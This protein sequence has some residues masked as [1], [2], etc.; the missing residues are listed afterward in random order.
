MG[1]LFI[2]VINQ[3]SYLEIKP[4]KKMK[5][6]LLFCLLVSILSSINYSK[7]YAQKD[8]EELK[9][10]G[11][12]YFITTPVSIGYLEPYPLK[13]YKPDL[14]K[15]RDGAKIVTPPTTQVATSR[16][17]MPVEIIKGHIVRIVDIEGDWV[18]FKYLPFDKGTSQQS[19][20]SEENEKLD[21]WKQYNEYDNGKIKIFR[22]GKIEFL[23]YTKPFF[24]RKRGFGVGAYSVPIRWRNS[25]GIYEFDSNLSIGSSLLYRIS[26]NRKS[27]HSFVDF[28][29]GLS[30]TKVNLNSINSDLGKEETDYANIDVLNP[31]ALTFTLG[32]TMNLAKNINVGSYYGWDFL[33]TA[34]QKTNWIYNKKPWLGF[35]VN[36]SF[37]NDKNDNTSDDGEN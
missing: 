16:N 32:I 13:N 23:K 1:I 17:N 18:F 35:G 10:D 22:L 31:T 2:T 36:I 8:N 37:N 27:E 7:I 34:D 29:T 11:K 26:L 12:Y 24:D 6:T 3:F 14:L 4:P 19:T 21:F 20:N 30:I 15:K 9:I 25:K 33:S 5:Q 28:S